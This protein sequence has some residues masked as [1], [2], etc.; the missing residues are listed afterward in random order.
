M[1]ILKRKVLA[2]IAHQGQLLVFRHRDFPE[3]GLQVPAGTLA[4]GETP[5][6]A[7]L[8]EAA[9]ETG[10]D[11]LLV[12]RKLG[13]QVLKMDA[14]GPDEIHHRY[15]YQLV[16]PEAPPDTWQHSEVSPSDGSPGPIVFE[17]FWARLPNVPPLASNQDKFL[18]RLIDFMIAEG[19]WSPRAIGMVEPYAR[20]QPNL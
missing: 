9:E 13:E 8:R 14:H 6:R 15:F 12:V 16:S 4:E 10:L 20:Q 18:Y 11:G 2:Y 5:E 1:P 7:V 17:F 19:A 3:A